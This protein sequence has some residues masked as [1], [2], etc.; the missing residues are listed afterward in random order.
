MPD[1]D[2]FIPASLPVPDAKSLS[3]MN[4]LLADKPFKIR[5]S[6]GF[7]KND[8]TD[9][10]N[11]DFLL[12]TLNDFI[13]HIQRCVANTRKILPADE[14]SPYYTH[15]P[16]EQPIAYEALAI[17]SAIDLRK[18]GT[19]VSDVQKRSQDM[20]IVHLVPLV[21]YLYRFL[22]RI[23]YLGAP[24]MARLYKAAHQWLLREL[25]PSDPESLKRSV[26][27]AIEEWYYIFNTFFPAMYPLVLR[28]VS[29]KC[30][31]ISQLFYANG[32]T[33]LKWLY[34][35]PSDILFVRG[36]QKEPEPVSVVSEEVPSEPDI[37]ESVA[38]GLSF[39]E[40]LFPEAG[41]DSLELLP[42]FC[43]YFLPVLNFQDAFIQL[44]PDNPL[45]QT[46]ILFWILE[47]LFQGLRQIKFEALSQINYRDE[48][49]DINRILEDWILYQEL[50]LDKSFSNDLKA[51]THQIYTQP[52]FNK[53]PYGRKLL[54]TM[55]VTI[56]A[57]FLPHFDIRLYGG[58][59]LVKDDRLPPFYTRVRRL[60]RLLE[61]YYDSIRDSDRPSDIIADG[62]VPGILN[63]WDGYRFDIPNV[64]SRR[65]DALCGGRHSRTR[66]NALLIRST[67]MILN[68][69]DWWI[70]DKESFAYR[71]PPDYLYRVVEPGN[72]VP[73]FGVASRTDIDVVF[74]K[75]LKARHGYISLSTEW[76]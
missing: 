4:A 49:E 69:L 15:F 70:N 21:H 76:L 56:K 31:S 23:Y 44:A 19:M 42:D 55:Y 60:Q 66:T 52:D 12:Y 37:P 27:D 46:L 25:V 11:P 5:L 74:M 41:W 10:V 32:S 75:H 22:I 2:I 18:L 24:E 61:R 68:V 1:A 30:M 40:A 51:Y 29:T 39:L 17:I 8:V 13:G 72:P 38:E 63:P 48:T 43:P 9:R 47:E 62:T 50:V 58:A 65:L 54:S 28:M 33:V 6:P 59:K 7:L 73:A 71:S 35:E 3:E 16:R 53:S 34:L 64:V 14:G 20:Q 26:T 45:H 67:L 36:G 57:V